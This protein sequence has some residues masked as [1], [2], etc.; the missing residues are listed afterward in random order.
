MLRQTAK[1]AIRTRGRM[2][3]L[4]VGAIACVILLAT[5]SVLV[6]RA[7]ASDA[8]A[9]RLAT[10]E[11]SS[12]VYAE[13]SIEANAISDG[14]YPAAAERERVYI[15]TQLLAAIAGLRQA[16]VRT[17]DEGNSAPIAIKFDRDV[18]AALRAI[19]RG[20]LRTAERIDLVRI[21]PVAASFSAR[22]NADSARLAVT[23]R[24]D[25]RIA[26]L[27]SLAVALMA[28]LFLAWFA[29]RI[30]VVERKAAHDAGIVR[31]KTD[32]EDELRRAQKMDAAGRLAAGVAHDFNNLLTGIL[33][34]AS[35]IEARAPAGEPDNKAAYEII[36]CAQ[37]AS[38]LTRQLLAFGQRQELSA[39]ELSLRSLLDG[40]RGLFLGV[41]REDVELAYDLREDLIVFADGGQLEQVMLNLV[42][43]AQHSMPRGGAIDISLR[44]IQL[45]H[46]RSIRGESLAAGSYAQ[47]GVEDTGHG[48]DGE[49]IAKIFEPYFSTKGELGTGL[50][51]PTSAG[52]VAQSGGRIDLT[53]TPGLGTRFE[54]FLPTVGVRPLAGTKAPEISVH[55]ALPVAT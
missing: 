10:A 22:L 30:L 54:I 35:L 38:E 31:A 2:L 29:R 24:S 8:Q 49:T 42:V 34:Y 28:A 20:D 32:N 4:E 52:I 55:S 26:D 51:L 17:A 16:G 37:R 46:A 36:G 33:G 40:M 7:R 18:E 6:V 5:V 43:N 9:A 45:E 25:A 21:D 13:R 15:K 50:G 19:D 11:L 53:S 12:A 3:A 44:H 48:M 14:R 27:V 23:A 1:A 41:L 47:I 39:T